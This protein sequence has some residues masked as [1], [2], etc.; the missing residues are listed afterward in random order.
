MIRVTAVR[1]S[2]RY[3]RFAAVLW[4][5]FAL[6][7]GSL[8]TLCEAQSKSLGIFE[9]QS[10]V[11][12]VAPPG[13]LVYDP[14]AQTYTIA[15]AGANLWSTTDGFH[16]VWKKV[17]GDLS[18]TADIKFPDSSGNPNPHR[19]AI[20]I[21][22]Q[23]LDADSVYADAAQHGSGLTALQY[24]RA[25]GATT[26]D[27]ELE[28]SSPKRLRLVK[29]GDTITMFLSMNGEPLHPAG[30]SMQLHLVEPFY[31]GIGVCSHDVKVVE[32]A[33]FSNVALETLAP[34]GSS[35][36]VAS[37]SALQ[38]IGIEDNSR[39][40]MIYATPGCIEAPNWS[41]DGTTLLFNQDGKIMKIA[42]TGGTRSR[43]I[44]AMPLGAREATASLQMA[45]GWQL[46]APC[47]G[48]PRRA[49]I[50]FRRREEPR[51]W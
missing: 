33:V 32:K 31:A 2:G 12:S 44:S 13:T 26:Q 41:K 4:F 49:S 14:V 7:V 9:G 50:S 42:A 28:I 1:G 38:T 37:Y 16:F 19:K 39:R 43:S 8:R 22:R 47:Q 48:N 45:N 17:S 10:D 20:L 15:S 11:G 5:G 40:T 51:A 3:V 46:V 18:L 6:G 24:R 34:P 27:I 29:R 35:A 30:A 21:F 25:K 36:K 23:T